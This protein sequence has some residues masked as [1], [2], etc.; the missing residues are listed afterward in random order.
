MRVLAAAKMARC[1]V[2]VAATVLVALMPQGAGAQDPAAFYAGKSVELD[3]G[4][5]VGG[6]YD[7]YGR[8]L[9]RHLGRHIPGQ[10]SIVPQNRE[11]AG[12]ERGILY[13][14]NR[15]P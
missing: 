5:S 6:G 4:Y 3:I 11:G 1:W 15:T 12:S 8:L 14:Y 13:L 10:P 7:L 2:G 9:A